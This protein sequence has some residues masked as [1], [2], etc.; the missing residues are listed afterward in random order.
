MPFPKK[1]RSLLETTIQ[2]VEAPDYVWL[3]YAVCATEQD[4]CGWRGWMIEAAF[5]EIGELC[6]TRTGDRV[7]NAM[8]DQVCPRCGD[9]LFRTEASLRMVASEDQAR[10]EGRRGVDYEVDP[11]DYE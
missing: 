2:D 3:T 8:D 10:P 7:L 5:K 11:I 4:S 1:F 6:A 9:P